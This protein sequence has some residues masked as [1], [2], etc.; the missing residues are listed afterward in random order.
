[1]N[2]RQHD[3]PPNY[4]LRLHNHTMYP[5]PSI[6]ARTP[7]PPSTIKIEKCLVSLAPH[8]QKFIYNAAIDRRKGEIRSTKFPL[9][10]DQLTSL[11]HLGVTN[12][13][14]RVDL[15]QQQLQVV[16]HFEHKSYLRGVQ[17]IQV[18]LQQQKPVIFGKNP[19]LLLRIRLQQQPPVLQ[20]I[21]HRD[22]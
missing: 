8:V 11:K 4:W 10:R 6:P 7:R 9:S 3:F 14:Q 16:L 22:K 5:P 12:K 19:I 20:Q 1:M 17:N 15:L 21:F 2:L 18:K 13:Y